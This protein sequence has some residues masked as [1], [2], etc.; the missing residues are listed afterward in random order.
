[1]E[2]Q[3]TIKRGRSPCFL[4]SPCDT[5]RHF[6]LTLTPILTCDRPLSCRC[7]VKLAANAVSG[8]RPV[9]SHLQKKYRT[10]RHF[11]A[12]SPCLQS[13]CRLRRLNNNVIS[14]TVTQR[15]VGPPAAGRRRQVL[16]GLLFSLARRGSGGEFHTCQ[17]WG[18][19]LRVGMGG[20]DHWPLASLR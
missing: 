10:G 17:R 18:A 12:K 6:C 2:L 11:G 13:D 5:N 15:S 19:I 1:M 8:G 4:S 3:R 9:H 7:V 16:R 20:G 14:P